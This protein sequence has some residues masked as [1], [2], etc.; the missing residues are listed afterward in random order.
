MKNL[1]Y[2]LLI[3][4]S[5]LLFSCVKDPETTCSETLRPGDEKTEYSLISEKNKVRR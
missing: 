4:L 3:L 2:F 5:G 1:T